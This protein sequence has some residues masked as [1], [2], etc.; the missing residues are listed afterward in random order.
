MIKK[1]K[2]FC[3][4]F[5][6]LFFCNVTVFADESL[7]VNVTAV[8]EGHSSSSDDSG[9]GGGAISP[10][11][12]CSGYAYPNAKITVEI[13]DNNAGEFNA[14][15]DGTFSYK[16]Y[17]ITSGIHDFSFYAKD[18]KYRSSKK[19]SFLLDVPNGSITNV[20]NIFISP[21]ISSDKL[22]Y[23][24]KD[25]IKFDG[26]SMPNTPVYVVVNSSDGALKSF[27]KEVISDKNGYFEYDPTG[28]V[29]NYGDYFV[30]ARALYAGIFSAFGSSV[31]F[32]VIDKISLSASRQKCSMKVDLNKDCEVNLLDF[33][34]EFMWYKKPL[35][36]EAKKRF[37]FNND[38]KVDLADLSIMAS[39][40][41]K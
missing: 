36:K 37:D 40:W 20:S 15:N 24:A 13:D 26:Y 14:Y 28:S 11:V 34:V 27:S 29:F 4:V 23:G 38:G 31:D 7:D 6:L 19:L 5:S 35:T 2:I 21:T 10:Y 9:G 8:V 16:I 25:K 32:Q 22:E 12:N 33:V 3:S 1:T 17:G 39:Y 18:L 30:T 41:T